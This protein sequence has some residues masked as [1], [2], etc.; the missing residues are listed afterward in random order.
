MNALEAKN[1]TLEHKSKNARFLAYLTLLID[2]IRAECEA[3]RFTLDD[4]WLVLPKSVDGSDVLKSFSREDVALLEGWLRSQ[5]YSVVPL[6]SPEHRKTEFWCEHPCVRVE[7]SNPLVPTD[8]L[9][10]EPE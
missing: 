3:E 1:L 7:W 2:L 10:G 9:T 4:P 5:G 8:P 6:Q